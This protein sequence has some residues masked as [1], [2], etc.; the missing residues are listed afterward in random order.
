MTDLQRLPLGKNLESA[1]IGI[2]CLVD[3]RSVL[4]RDPQREAFEE[5]FYKLENIIYNIRVILYVQVNCT[6]WDENIWLCDF[7]VRNIKQSQIV[8]LFSL[9][10]IKKKKKTKFRVL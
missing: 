5:K 6:N 2:W 8:T 4:N 10:R 7:K 1:I 9:I 3:A